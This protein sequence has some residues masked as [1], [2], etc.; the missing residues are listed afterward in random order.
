[1]ILSKEALGVTLVII[2]LI[3]MRATKKDFPNLLQDILVSS[4]NNSRAG[5]NSASMTKPAFDESKATKKD[6]IR[7]IVGLIIVVIGA[8]IAIS[9]AFQPYF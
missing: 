6:K 7:V 8:V 9:S 2:G 5:Y 1:M 4:I 3:I